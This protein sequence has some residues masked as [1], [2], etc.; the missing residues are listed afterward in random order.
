MLFK[1]ATVAAGLLALAQVASAAPA[2]AS[3][4]CK[5]K[6]N[7]ELGPR[8]EYLV[9]DMDDSDLK[10]K[11]LSCLE[12]EAKPTRF[13]VGHRGGS[14]LQF[15]EETKEAY[16]AGTRMGAGIQECD[17]A[18]TKDKQLVCRH[19]QCD[20]HTTT[21]IL[22]TDL[23]SK[24]TTPF[25]PAANGKPAKAKCCTSDITLAEFK[26]LC[27]KMDG[28]NATATTPRRIRTAQGLDFTTELKAPEVPMPFDG[29]YTYDMYRQQLIDDYREA[30]IPPSR[31]WPQSF[32]FAD[33]VYWLANEPEFGK[34]AVLL[35]DRG[36][37]AELLPGATANLTFYKESGVKW[38]APP[39]PYLISTDENDNYIPSDYALKAMELGFDI[40]TWSL[41]RSGPLKLAAARKDYYYQYMLDGTKKDGDM[42]E[43]IDVMARQIGI[44][45]IFSD[46]SATV[47]FYA[48][49]FSL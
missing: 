42:Y 29:D 14:V 43:M 35:D 30:G 48:N 28:F 44:K 8:P 37:T 21:N 4:T 33:I 19:A 10:D 3:R 31:V 15:P 34:Q 45:G 24:C 16:V 32:V 5:P 40:I 25:E 26:S 47:T 9:N 12:K 1:P 38:L 39:L 13:S 23:A 17:S 22:V 6:R 27:G 11:L 41:E 20:L 18:F 2:P 7:V 46:W 49:C 36:E